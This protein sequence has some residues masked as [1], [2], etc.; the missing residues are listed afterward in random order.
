ML[1]DLGANVRRS[2]YCSTMAMGPSA[3]AYW[4]GLWHCPASPPHTFLTLAT[5]ALRHHVDRNT[6]VSIK[7]SSSAC[8]GFRPVRS[9]MKSQG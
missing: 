2:S 5:L 7:Q 4:L 9:L 8:E 6:D 3:C 1:P